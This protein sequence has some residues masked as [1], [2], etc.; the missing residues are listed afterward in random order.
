M[1]RILGIVADPPQEL[2]ACLVDAPRSL[3]S[4]SHEHRDGWGT[5]V[6]NDPLDWAIKKAP[7]SAFAD[8]RFAEAARESHGSVL[9]AHV[10]RGTVGP[11]SFLNTHPFKRGRWVFAHNGTIEQL[12][13]LRSLASPA[14]LGEIEGATDS[15]IFFAYL[16]TELDG[17][18]R[19]D[20]AKTVAHAVLEL[21]R[22]PS[23][24]AI[25]FL[26]SDG[27]TLYA[28]RLGRTLHVLERPGAVLVASERLTDEPWR[29]VEEGVVLQ[30]TRKPA[31]K[32][33]VIGRL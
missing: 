15:E 10:R 28:F 30:V 33:A 3:A 18:R 32:L 16:M 1:C 24:G 2:G 26:L 21:A 5:A 12:P 27:Q 22:R 23:F 9:I 4:L 31:P 25:N 19:E 7:L 17:V 8:A 29:E 20:E 6:F 13:F 11:V 14:R